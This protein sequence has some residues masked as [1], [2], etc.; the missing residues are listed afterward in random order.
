MEDQTVDPVYKKGFEQGYWLQRGNS[1]D[2]PDLMKKA[3]GHSVYSN[4]LKAGSKEAARE[5]F[6][7]Q[8]NQAREGQ[9]KDRDREKGMSRD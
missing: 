9:Y 1:V 8:L 7:E 4:G 6:K 3:E 2:L 5:Q